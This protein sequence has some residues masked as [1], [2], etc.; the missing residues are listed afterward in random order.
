MSIELKDEW[1]EK[2]IAGEV[3]PFDWPTDFSEGEREQMD[4]VGNQLAVCAGAERDGSSVR[5][6]DRHEGHVAGRGI[7]RCEGADVSEE[8]LEGCIP[9]RSAEGAHGGQGFR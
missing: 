5:Q 1:V 2:A 4:D 8:G 7:L 3:V 9:G 6:G